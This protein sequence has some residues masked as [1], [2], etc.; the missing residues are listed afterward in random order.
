MTVE[1]RINPPLADSPVF[2][3]KVRILTDGTAEDWIRWLMA[4]SEV[5]RSKPLL[6]G[7]S[8]VGMAQILLGGKAKETFQAKF[9]ELASNEFHDIN[10]SFMSSLEEL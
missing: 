4:W 6:T 3:K 2:S 5:V 9:L 10:V 8:K 1:M 7:N